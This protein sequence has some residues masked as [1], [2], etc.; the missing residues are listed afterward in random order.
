MIIILMFGFYDCVN[1]Q[2]IFVIKIDL[3]SPEAQKAK[4]QYLEMEFEAEMKEKTEKLKPRLIGCVWFN[5]NIEDPK[6]GRCIK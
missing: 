4:L 1:C 5:N 2:L 6:S 3:Q